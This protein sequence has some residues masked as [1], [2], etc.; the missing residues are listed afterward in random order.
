MQS[1]SYRRATTATEQRKTFAYNERHVM[2]TN[3]AQQ[4]RGRSQYAG[5]PAKHSACFLAFCG[6]WSM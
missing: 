2:N 1:S 3:T 4:P 6:P 5:G